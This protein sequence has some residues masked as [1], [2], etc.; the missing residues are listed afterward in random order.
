VQ[1]LTGTRAFS[2]AVVVTG[3][4]P[5]QTAEVEPASIGVLVAGQVPTLAAIP[6][7][8]VIASVDAAG[9]GP[10]TYTADVAVRVPSNVTVQTVQ[11]TRVTITIRNR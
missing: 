9:R 8:Q 3:L 11:P 1:P 6:T 7:G 4:L 5:S 10:G 2:A